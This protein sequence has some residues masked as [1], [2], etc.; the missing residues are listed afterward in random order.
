[1]CLKQD[2]SQTTQ[3]IVGEKLYVT[4]PCVRYGKGSLTI[5]SMNLGQPKQKIALNQNQT[6]L[7]VTEAACGR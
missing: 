3:K 2:S 1:V 5:G 7:K 6:R 4:P